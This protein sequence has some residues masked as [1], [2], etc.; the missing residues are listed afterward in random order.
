[1]S[2]T[3]SKVWISPREAAQEEWVK[4]RDNL[5]RV[6]FDRSPFAPHNF[7]E[8]VD[9][10]AT[11]AEELAEELRKHAEFRQVKQAKSGQHAWIVP[12]EGKM[13]H[14]NLSP[15]LAMQSIW[16]PWFVHTEERPAA[17]WPAPEEFKEEGDERHTSGFGRFLPVPRKPGN[18]TVVWKQKQFIKPS[19]MDFVNPVLLREVLP[20]LSRDEQYTLEE[21][22][23]AYG[24]GIYTDEYAAQTT[25]VQLLHN[26]IDHVT[27]TRTSSFAAIPTCGKASPVDL[28]ILPWR[29]ETN[30][31]L[32]GNRDNSKLANIDTGLANSEHYI[33]E[34]PA[35]DG[36]IVNF[37]AKLQSENHDCDTLVNIT[38]IESSESEDE[39]IEGRCQRVS[40]PIFS[41]IL[42]GEDNNGGQEGAMAPFTTVNLLKA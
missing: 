32:A 19:P 10:R 41:E 26:G 3:N 7:I 24:H 29:Q 36:H 34:T 35:T 28:E 11:R 9:F 31:A 2:Y 38:P 14:D 42:W 37:A 20:G 1:M 6:R 33:T 12:F 25:P 4:V 23:M 27:G 39:D 40:G 15:I 30:R 8:Y 13:F 22:F 5:G 21:M 16:C 17:P 18:E